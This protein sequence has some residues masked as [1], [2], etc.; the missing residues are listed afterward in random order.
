MAML[1][2]CG[3]QQFSGPEL[4]DLLRDAGFHDTRVTPTFGY[5]SVVVGTKR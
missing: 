2:W 1:A 4:V 3:G 5:W